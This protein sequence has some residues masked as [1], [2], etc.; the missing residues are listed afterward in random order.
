MAGKEILTLALGKSRRLNQSLKL[1][2]LSFPICLVFSELYVE[3]LITSRG[4][5]YESLTD[6]MLRRKAMGIYINH[7]ISIYRGSY[8]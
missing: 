5:T 7:P 4:A 2:V 3:A 8:Q 6:A 1:L